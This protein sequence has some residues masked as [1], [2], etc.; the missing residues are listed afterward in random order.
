MYLGTK[1]PDLFSEAPRPSFRSAKTSSDAANQRLGRVEKSRNLPIVKGFAD[2][3]LS[4]TTESTQGS[5]GFTDALNSIAVR[6][7]DS[8]S[9]ESVKRLQSAVGGRG[10]STARSGTWFHRQKVSSV[11]KKPVSVTPDDDSLPSAI[12]IRRNQK[13]PTSHN[14]RRAPSSSMPMKCP[15]SK[16][17][18]KS[19]QQSPQPYPSSHTIV[20]EEES[21][22]L[23]N[24][25]DM[26]T[27]DMYIRITEARKQRASISDPN[28]SQIPAEQNGSH[29]IPQQ[30]FAD[31]D[32]LPLPPS[33]LDYGY[34]SGAADEMDSP[35]LIPI[36]VG[37]SGH[38]MIF[39]DLE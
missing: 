14:I 22:H 30:N 13:K 20:D 19:R 5:P 11:A 10:S 33:Q 27:W 23:R 8:R 1:R 21:D 4:K 16:S 35:G 12:D 3:V 7:M 6:A 29:F 2:D 39:G 25:Y 36:E 26:R 24:M 37:G 17:S 18:R 34:F 15:P 28:L 38:E 9:D 31:H 32:G